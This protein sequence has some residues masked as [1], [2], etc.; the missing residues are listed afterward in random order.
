MQ[1]QFEF[2]KASLQCFLQNRVETAHGLG[3]VEKCCLP[4]CQ[5]NESAMCHANLGMLRSQTDVCYMSGM[6]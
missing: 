1:N 5:A 6:A 2:W 3:L 4:W